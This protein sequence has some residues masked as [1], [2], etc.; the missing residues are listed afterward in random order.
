MSSNPQSAESAKK[1]LYQLLIPDIGSSVM[2]EWLTESL[3]RLPKKISR[4]Q[5]AAHLIG[6]LSTCPILLRHRRLIERLISNH[7]TEVWNLVLASSANDVERLALARWQERRTRCRSDEERL[8]RR[9]SA[10][11]LH[12]RVRSHKWI[13][14]PGLIEREFSKSSV[15]DVHDPWHD[16]FNFLMNADRRTC[17]DDIF[18]GGCVSRSAGPNS[19]CRLFGKSR[20]SLPKDLPFRREGRGYVYDY[21]AVVTCIRQLLIKNRWLTDARS[22]PIILINVVLC[23]YKIGSPPEIAV[24]FDEAIEP[25]LA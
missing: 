11:R 15:T 16:P 25:F 1:E 6:E 18:L 3:K 14:S 5:V 19:L 4:Q 10:K 12:D 22:R 21:R 24:S 20:K 23:A 7:S 9:R 8:H 13:P 17:L 2:V